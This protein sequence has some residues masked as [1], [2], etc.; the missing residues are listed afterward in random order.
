VRRLAGR[1]A[2]GWAAAA[3]YR[4][5]AGVEPPKDARRAADEEFALGLVKFIERTTGTRPKLSTMRTRDYERWCYRY[6][7]AQRERTRMP[8]YA[9]MPT[10][11]KM[12]RYLHEGEPW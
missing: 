4:E 11:G 8:S 1:Q 2:H 5:R 12:W 6:H 9:E 7:E 10:Y 3:L